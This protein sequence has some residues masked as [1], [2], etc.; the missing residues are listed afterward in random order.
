[1]SALVL[2]GILER[3]TFKVFGRGISNPWT[4][5]G[6]APNQVSAVLGLG[7]LV[8]FFLV[9]EPWVRKGLRLVLFVGMVG[10]A[11]QSALT[12]SRGGLYMAA[13]SAV[14]AS[15]FL[16]RDARSRLT[17][18]VVLALCF[19]IGRYL[20]VPQLDALT[21]GT[22]V[23]RFQD[24][25]M[26]GREEIMRTDLEL[27][28]ENPVLGVGPGMSKILRQDILGGEWLLHSHT[29]FTRLLSEHGALGA[30]AL[31][32]LLLGAARAIRRA[33]GRRG[34]AYS[35][36]LIVWS[37]LFMVINAMR[38]VTPSFL[39]GLAFANLDAEE[40]S[41]GRSRLP[42]PAR[43]HADVLTGGVARA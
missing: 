14:V 10:L 40:A 41:P 8:C 37:L 39:F 16:M 12:Y 33:P 38:L 11:T 3:P 32:L 19:V 42:D 27:W 34:R 26:T 4:S 25:G 20:I 5:G 13:G 23:Q 6:F 31:V 15:L 7:A 17:T 30:L 35:A 24:T 43:R 29:E 9:R 21:G 22:L 1:V 2:T 36:A 18:V 28:S